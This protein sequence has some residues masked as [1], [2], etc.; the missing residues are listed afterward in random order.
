MTQARVSITPSDA[1]ADQRLT[2][3]QCRLLGLIGSYLG[4]DHKAWPSQSTLA[5]QLGVSRKAVNDGV[6]ALKKYGYIEVEKRRRPDGGQTSNCY[7]VVMDPQLRQGDT[8]CEGEVTP[9]SPEG[10]T[11]C[12]PLEVTP[13]VT[14]E[15]DTMKD[16][17]E[18]PNEDTSKIYDDAFDKIWSTWSTAGRKRSKARRACIDTL[19]RAAKSHD[20]TA[21]V[22]AAQMY[23]KT[24]DGN[25]HKGL[26]SW[27][28]GGFY[29]AWFP[30][31]PRTEQPQS[32]I[33]PLEQCFKIFATTGD[34][35]GDRYGH[36]FPPNHPS[37]RYPSELYQ[38]YQL[39]R[40]A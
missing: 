35:E 29:E 7:F 39:R 18:R 21:L 13:P 33:A 15:G 1:W 17:R 16:P 10:D 3:L 6:K 19:K 30:K 40:A 14:P 8:P 4:K 34:W 32:K 27:L 24:T 5:E 25:Y 26:H 37:A 36:R 28:A 20:L 38:K 22:R 9:P 31:A 23:A 2:P 11:P 12:N